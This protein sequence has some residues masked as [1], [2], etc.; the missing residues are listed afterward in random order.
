MAKNY[1]VKNVKF[2][3]IICLKLAKN[4]DFRAKTGR[5]KIAYLTKTGTKRV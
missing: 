2:L 4:V 5:F 3:R 1:Y